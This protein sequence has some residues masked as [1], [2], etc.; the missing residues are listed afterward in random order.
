MFLLGPTT[1]RHG[2]PDMTL[3]YREMVRSLHANGLF[4]EKAGRKTVKEIIDAFAVGHQIFEEK[5]LSWDS[6]EP[7]TMVHYDEDDIENGIDMD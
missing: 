6:D 1:V 2:E 4:E 5:G 7:E 3:T